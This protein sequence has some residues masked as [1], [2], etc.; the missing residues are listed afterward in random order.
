MG[1]HAILLEIMQIVTSTIRTITYPGCSVRGTLHRGVLHP[2]VPVMWYGHIRDLFP[3]ADGCKGSRLPNVTLLHWAQ[4][5][6]ALV[7][8]DAYSIQFS[9][10][11]PLYHGRREEG[12]GTE[13]EG[14]RQPE[15]EARM[16]SCRGR[17]ER[18]GGRR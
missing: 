6:Y 2:G 11:T 10:K 3:T 7:G 16:S 1:V 15:G 4:Q 5:R 9:L 8:C 18:E 13:E 12:G 17:G 14:P